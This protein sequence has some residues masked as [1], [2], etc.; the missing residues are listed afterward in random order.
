[1]KKID[2][3][4]IRIWLSKFW[5]RGT[6]R[7]LLYRPLATVLVAV[8]LHASGRGVAR[9]GFSQPPMPVFILNRWLTY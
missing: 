8:P 1:M 9:W 5:S 7:L 3:I 6:M 2:K 4:D